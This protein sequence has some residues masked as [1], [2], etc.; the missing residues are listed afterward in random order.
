MLVALLAMS[1]AQGYEI[2]PQVVNAVAN[3]SWGTHFEPAISRMELKGYFTENWREIAT[4]IEALPSSRFD[5]KYNKD[6]V[7]STISTFYEDC[8]SLTPMEYLDFLDQM[9][10]LYED[11][12]ISHLAFKLLLLAENEKE[13]FLSVNYE[14]PRVAEILKKAIQLVPAE[15][16]SLRSCLEDMASGKLADNYKT[17]K[18]DDAP[19]PQTLPGIKLKRPWGSLIRKYERVTGKKLPPDP[20]FPDEDGVRPERRPEQK[21][22]VEVEEVV[23]LTPL[24]KS[25]VGGSLALVAALIA[26]GIARWRKV[27]RR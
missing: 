6:R 18:E 17:N 23:E 10:I 14:H 2:P 4:N 13:D 24:G 26:W 5:P 8:G 20:D 1:I 22:S 11:E 9:L 16:E 3:D 15:D 27:R 19:L 21:D 12:R 25:L 7:L